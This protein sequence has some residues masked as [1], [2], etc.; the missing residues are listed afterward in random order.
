MD[1]RTGWWLERSDRP[2]IA[3]W[4]GVRGRQRGGGGHSFI[5]A[6]FMLPACL[7]LLEL[8]DLARLS[9]H[10][11]FFLL[12]TEECLLESHGEHAIVTRQRRLLSSSS[13]LYDSV[14]AWRFVAFLSPREES[15][16]P[17]AG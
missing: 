5:A 8:F 13:S 14:A 11:M 4:D 10:C 16:R 1:G 17:P 3:R 2:S 6:A 15:N 7:S 12:G 9:A